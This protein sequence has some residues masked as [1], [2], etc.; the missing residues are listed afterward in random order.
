MM[1]LR[2]LIFKKTKKKRFLQII[3]EILKQDHKE[4]EIL[5]NKNNYVQEKIGSDQ[6]KEIL[7]DKNRF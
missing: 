2:L 3:T 5:T 6:S 4:E 1:V 7:T